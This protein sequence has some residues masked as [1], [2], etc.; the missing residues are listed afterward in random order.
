MAIVYAHIRLDTNQ[1]FYVGISMN[2]IRPHNKSKRN[3][4]WKGIVKRTPY[5]VQILFDNLTWE[6][7]CNKEIELIKK[8]GRVDNNTGILCNLTD[9]GEGSNN[10]KHK[11]ESKDKI[12]KAWKGKKRGPQSKEHKQKMLQTKRINNTFKGAKKG[13]KL[14]EDVKKKISNS[15]S[16]NKYTCNYCGKIGINSIMFRWHFEN[17]KHKPK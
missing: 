15:V 11:Q 16:Q 10:F 1:I 17:C 8:Y 2:D 13:V 7:A 14:S 3:K 5:K 12:G 9:G 6:E 4:I